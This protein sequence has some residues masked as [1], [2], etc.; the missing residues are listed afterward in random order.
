MGKKTSKGLGRGLGKGLGSLLG[1]EAVEAVVQEDLGA[2]KADSEDKLHIHLLRIIDVEPNASQPRSSFTEEKIDELADSIETHGV[3]QPITVRRIDSGSYQIIAGERRWRAARKAGLKEIPAIIIEADDL[4]ATELAMVENLQREDLNPVEEA[5][6]YRVLMSTYGLKQEEVAQRVGRSRSAVAN[7]VRLLS[8]ESSVLE[9]LR[10]GDL[11]GGHART[12]LTLP[13][14]MQKLLAERIISQQLSVRQTEALVKKIQKL[15]EQDVQVEKD[16]PNTVT[17]DYIKVLQQEL[18]DNIGRKVK[19]IDG[20]KK[21]RIE[22]EYY[23]NDDL[24]QLVE[25]LS[26]LGNS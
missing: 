12:L 3:L 11:S 18:G 14:K 4:K 21:G 8:L 7:A 1:E 26:S 17:V 10:N 20:K 9:M 6:G 16:A 2:D 25:M 5:E 19:I 24:N 15:E 23:G 22:I 13:E